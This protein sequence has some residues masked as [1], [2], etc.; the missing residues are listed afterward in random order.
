[1][2]AQSRAA[3]EHDGDEPACRLAELRVLHEQI[4]RWQ[5]MTAIARSLSE[6]YPTLAF[7]SAERSST[8]AVYADILVR[9]ELTTEGETFRR[10]ADFDAV[11]ARINQRWR[12]TADAELGLAYVRYA[13]AGMAVVY[14]GPSDLT[15]LLAAD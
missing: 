6:R 9:R 4:L 10:T 5:N 15:E 11:P 13:A 1:M 7:L 3:D 8:D 12:N 2:V 14:R